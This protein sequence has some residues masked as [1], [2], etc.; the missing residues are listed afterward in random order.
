MQSTSAHKKE[1]IENILRLRRAERVADQNLRGELASVRGFLED[2]VGRTVRTADAARL[3]GVTQPALKR[4]IDKGEISALMTPQGRY[5]VPV[6]ELVDLLDETEQARAEGSGRPLASVIRDR[7]RR[8]VETVDLDRLLPRKRRTHRTAEQVAL[9]YH[10]VVAERLDENI[11]EEARR[12]VDRWRQ[13]GSVHPHWV[14][15]WE[16]VLVMALP[17]IAKTISAD[18][19]RARELRQTSPFAGVLNQQERTRLV[20]AVE[21]RE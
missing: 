1:T 4:W 21:G 2:S 7:R 11:V 3:L 6:S 20:D 9:A 16:R 14:E 13:K 8:S 19:P 17:Q 5:E 18:T 12:R 10:R 15:E